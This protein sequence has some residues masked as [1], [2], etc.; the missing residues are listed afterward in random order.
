MIKFIVSLLMLM[1]FNLSVVK[2]DSLRVILKPTKENIDL[3]LKEGDRASI[4]LEILPASDKVLAFTAQLED[5]LILG[6]FKVLKI[7]SNELSEH[8]S[9][10]V[11]STLDVVFLGEK[12][13]KPVFSILGETPQVEIKNIKFESLLDL[14]KAPEF[15]EIKLNKS[16]IE[17]Y[18]VALSIFL[19]ILGVVL[20]AFRYRRRVKLTEKRK[21]ELLLVK[22]N[23]YLEKIEKARNR[24]EIE[25]VFYDLKNIKQF[26]GHDSSLSSFKDEMIKRG[27][28]KEWNDED[29]KIFISKL[30]EIKERLAKSEFYE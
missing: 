27:Y 5:K 8:N 3:I 26:F 18:G 23:K 4:I 10:V 28:K 1:N 14:N 19:F 25:K 22:K 11:T 2:A 7:I 13:F 24:E 15:M 29:I 20:Y 17:S 21:I 30:G 6:S 9:D 12:E 16:F